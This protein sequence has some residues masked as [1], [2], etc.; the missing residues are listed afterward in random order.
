VTKTEADRRAS[1]LNKVPGITVKVVRIL[2]EHVDP[3]R[4]GDNGWDLEITVND[5]T[6]LM[7]ALNLP[8]KD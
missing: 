1:R 6:K 7:G 4:Q 5:A 2:P 3:P 8:Q